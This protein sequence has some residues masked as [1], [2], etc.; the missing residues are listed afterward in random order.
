M[1]IVCATQDSQ[2][3]FEARLYK[4]TASKMAAAQARY[5]VNC[6]GGNKGQFTKAH[7]DYVSELAWGMITHVPA[8][9]YVSPEMVLGKHFEPMARA[10]YM[11][12]Y[13]ADVT[14]TG[15]V[16]H[17]TMDY[18][19]A[20][21]DG[22][23]DPNGGVEIKVPKV[24]THQETIEADAIP[25]E[26]LPQMYTNMLCCEREWWDFVSFCPPDEQFGPEAMMMPDELRMFRKRLYADKE[27]FAEIEECAKVTIDQALEK[28]AFILRMYPAKSAP[29]SKLVTELELSHEALDSDPG[30]FTGDGYAFIDDIQV[31]P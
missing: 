4:V 23:V 1:R 9:H 21:P 25:E 2:E 27:K 16:L 26:Y 14:R 29:K 5:K 10:E 22:L 13:D 12:R 19:G 6:K 3:W 24:R 15:F 28:V 18:L 7:F 20:S 8:D 17:P 30:D 31:T 11:D